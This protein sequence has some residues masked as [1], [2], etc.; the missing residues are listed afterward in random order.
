M[1]NK[2]VSKSSTKELD[3]REVFKQL[4]KDGINND[5]IVKDE[6]IWNFHLFVNRQS[7]NRLL[8]F[9]EMYSK[10]LNVPGVIMELGVFYGRDLVNLINLR[11]TYEPNNYTRKIIG[12]DTFGEGIPDIVEDDGKIAKKGDFSVP[13]GYDIYLEQLLKYHESE[14]GLPH[15]KKFELVKGNVLTTLPEY[16]KENPETIISLIYFDMDV[17]LPTKR[18]LEVIKPYL[19]K[20]SIIGLDDL[21]FHAYPGETIAVKEVLGFNNCRLYRIPHD[22]VSSY[23]VFGE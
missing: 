17:Y 13:E 11:G 15:I 21:N 8:F 14:C 20:G 10:I 2:S 12:F 19:T 16:L 23:M 4:I 1:I 9:Q 5:L 6:L 22:P 18:C 7:F 3:N